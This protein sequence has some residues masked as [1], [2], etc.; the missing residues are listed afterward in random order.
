MAF[1]SH[2]IIANEDPKKALPTKNP[3]P[4]ITNF[5]MVP[6]SFPPLF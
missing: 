5:N 1:G 3:K 6:L 4:M 2:T